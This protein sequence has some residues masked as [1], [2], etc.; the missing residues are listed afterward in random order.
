MYL[1][2]FF[3]VSLFRAR[4]RPLSPSLSDRFVPPDEM[5]NYSSSTESFPPAD[6]PPLRPRRLPEFF[7][8]LS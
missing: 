3:I 5:K 4:K 8:S 6:A 1:N 2:L 7:S